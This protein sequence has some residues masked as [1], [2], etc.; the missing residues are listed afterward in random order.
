MHRREILRETSRETFWVRIVE[1]IASGQS[2]VFRR[3]MGLSPDGI[4]HDG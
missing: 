3:W 2:P 4:S 1:S